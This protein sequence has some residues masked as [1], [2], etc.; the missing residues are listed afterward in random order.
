MYCVVADEMSDFGNYPFMWARNHYS[1]LSGSVDVQTQ[2]ESKHIRLLLYV[3]TEPQCNRGIKG[4]INTVFGDAT[5]KECRVQWWFAKVPFLRY[6]SG[7]WTSRTRSTSYR[8][9]RTQVKYDPHQSVMEHGRAIRHTLL[10]PRVECYTPKLD[11]CTLA[12]PLHLGIQSYTI[13]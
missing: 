1:M 2:H 12:D 8:K 5:V 11:P 13:Q 10:A 4:N 9:Q 3:Q 7:K 6:D